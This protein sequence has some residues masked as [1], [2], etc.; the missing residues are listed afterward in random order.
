MIATAFATQPPS[1]DSRPPPGSQSQDDAD[2]S[3]GPGRRGRI[4]IV[5]DE[6]LVA[7]S[8]EWALQD[9][10]FEV[11]AVVASGEDA[12]A[13]AAQLV[14]DLALMDVR[15]AGRL[16]GIDAALALRARGIPCLFASA[17]SDPGTIDRGQKAEPLGW[18]RKPFTDAALVAAVTDAM[19]RL[20]GVE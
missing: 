6:Y 5:E 4:L 16:D 20:G 13:A 19:G 18:L 8:S 1:Q 7:L 12:I 3:P 15:L 2:A 9:A 10:G 14:P 17:N 11:L